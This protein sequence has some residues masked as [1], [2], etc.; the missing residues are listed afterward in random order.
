MS[1]TAVITGGGRGLG[2]AFARALADS[3]FEVTIIA[4]S[5]NEL[6]ETAAAIGGLRTCRADVTDAQGIGE[7]F[8]EIGPVDVLVNNAAIFGPIGPFAETDF[9][10]WWGPL[11]V[12]VRGAMLCTRAVLPGMLERRRGR[13]I[14][15]ATG[16]FSGPYLSAYLT[17]KTALIR[18]TECIAAET[19]AAG[20]AMFSISPGTV[21]TR[22]STHS[23]TS[24]EGRKWIP[25]YS[26][27]FDE[28]V[29]LPPERPAALVAALASGKYDELSGLYLTVFDDLDE[30]LASVDE[31][32]EKKE[33]ALTIR[34]HHINEAARKAMAIREG[35]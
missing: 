12:N 14:N 20:V 25:W 31:V 2:R 28:G 15:V 17:S 24:P 9:D 30:V 13:I 8:R 35:R 11:D 18:A 34:P 4:R 27:I 16:A 33:H 29:D 10:Q 21:R 1:Q 22:M 19:K 5:Q 23:L 6:D 32:R 3:G 7:A 26:R